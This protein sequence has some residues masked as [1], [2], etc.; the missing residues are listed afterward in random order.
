MLPALA[1]VIVFVAGRSPDLARILA[2]GGYVGGVVWLLYMLV[3]DAFGSFGKRLF[4]LRVVEV[5]RGLPCSWWRSLVRNTVLWLM[6][7]VLVGGLIEVVLAL[8]HPRGQ[9]LGDMLAGTEIWED[10]GV[11]HV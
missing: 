8:F 11:G 3:R 4:G 10:G 9:R 2:Q 7:L 5:P 1:G 6:I